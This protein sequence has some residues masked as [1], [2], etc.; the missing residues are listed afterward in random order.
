MNV[1]FISDLHFEHKNIGI[2]RDKKD[3]DE[4]LIAQWNSVVSKRDLTWVLGDVAM[5]KEGIDLVSRLNG[6]KHLI[7]GNHDVHALE[8]YQKVFNKIHGFMKYKG[9]WLSHAPIHKKHLR[10]VKN[11]HGHTHAKEISNFWRR[12]YLC[13]CVEAVN[14]KPISLKALQTM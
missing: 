6:V 3:H 1:R 4:W 13:V 9:F 11:I 7:L 8:R 5:R 14:G 10:G 2:W 12:D